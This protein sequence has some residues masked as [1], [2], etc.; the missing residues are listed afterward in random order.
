MGGISRCHIHFKKLYFFNLMN[1]KGPLFYS[2]IF[3]SFTNCFSV[4]SI[5]REKM[6]IQIQYI[7]NKNT[8]CMYILYPCINWAGEL[9]PKHF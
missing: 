2:I 9:L 6:K 1:A 8:Y 5:A 4:L 3:F 7:L